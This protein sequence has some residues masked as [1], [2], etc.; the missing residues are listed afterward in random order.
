MAE[1]GDYSRQC[2]QGFSNE[3]VENYSS[4]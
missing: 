2:G 3:D 1:N 4:F